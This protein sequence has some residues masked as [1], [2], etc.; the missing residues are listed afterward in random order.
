MTIGSDHVDYLK[1]IS[2]REIAWLNNYATIKPD[3]SVVVKSDAQLS[4][5]A[6][7]ALYKK[8]MNVADFLLPNKKSYVAATLWHWDIHASNLFI[9]ADT[10]EISGLIDWQDSWVGPLFLQARH[11]RLVDYNGEIQLRLPDSF[12]AIADKDEKAKIRAKVERS[13]LIWSYEN[14][15]KRINPVLHEILHVRQGRTRR[16]TVDM[17]SNT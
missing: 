17:A 16:D 15:T 3:H 11:P 10:N 5:E 7:I 13:I 8:F 1:A 4:V 12:K 14:D 6:H 2:R 9:N